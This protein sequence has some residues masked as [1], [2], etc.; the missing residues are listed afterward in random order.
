VFASTAC[1]ALVDSGW[2]FRSPDDAVAH[3]NRRP[4]AQW[5]V[6]ETPHSAGEETQCKVSLL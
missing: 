3:N 4:A 6:F 5:P 1:I 2:N